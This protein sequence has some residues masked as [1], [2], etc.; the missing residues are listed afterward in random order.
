MQFNK[1]LSYVEFP[2]AQLSEIK[3]LVL[4]KTDTGD[5]LNLAGPALNRCG[6]RWLR[7]YPGSFTVPAM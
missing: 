4:E 7:S 3:S 1:D 5:A 2:L 6:Y